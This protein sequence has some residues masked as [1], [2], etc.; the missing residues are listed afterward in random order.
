MTLQPLILM[1]E[2]EPAMR[3]TLRAA[4]QDQGY[5][6]IEA[7][8]AQDGLYQASLRSPNLI[9]LDLGLPDKDG[10]EV[11]RILRR[12]QQVPIIVISARDSEQQQI[13]ALDAGA[14]DYVEKPF[15][16]GELLARVRAS[17]R[18]AHSLQQQTSSFCNGRL[19][20]DFTRQTVLLHEE[21]VPLTPTQ[22]RLLAM[23]VR[24][25][26]RVL[27]HKVL[28]REVWG[29]SYVNDLQYLRVFM[30]QLR[31]KLELDPAQPRMLVTVRRVGYRFKPS[32]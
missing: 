11:A 18:F 3:L 20:V 31:E 28:L 2:D 26:G 9:L 13:E 30:K 23:L 8:N 21:V 29:P 14:N 15:R 10:V 1:I 12:S 7:A 22:F 24:Q 27:T 25:P 19:R 16:Q 4:L 32:D 6:T 17:I 5:A